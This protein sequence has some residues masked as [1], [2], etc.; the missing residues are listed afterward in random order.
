[1]A[2]A[3]EWDD[4]MYDWI[5]DVPENDRARVKDLYEKAKTFEA[6]IELL[7]TWHPK[8]YL[9]LNPIKSLSVNSSNLPPANNCSSEMNKRLVALSEFLVSDQELSEPVKP[10][11]RCFHDPAPILRRTP[12]SA[13]LWC[14]SRGVAMPADLLSGRFAGISLIRIQESLFSSGKG[15]DNTGQQPDELSD[16]MSIGP[17]ND[18]R[19]RDATPVHQ[20]VSLGS[21]FSPG[22]SD[23]ARL[24]PAQGEL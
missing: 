13:F 4:T 1:M 12:G 5:G 9:N 16:V 21:F 8:G 6:K 3:N 18:Q 19:Q 7:K 11:V 15:N 17:C 20:Y 22:P 23:W 10:G 24:L 2:N 14:D